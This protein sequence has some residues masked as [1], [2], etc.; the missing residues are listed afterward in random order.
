MKIT[1]S[2]LQKHVAQLPRSDRI[3]DVLVR[4]FSV[5]LSPEKAVS[6][7][8]LIDPVCAKHHLDG[9]VATIIRSWF[10]GHETR[11]RIN[12]VHRPIVDYLIIESIGNR[13][14]QDSVWALGHSEPDPHDDAPG[15]LELIQSLWNAEQISQFCRHVLAALEQV[16][17]KDI[18]IDS[19]YHGS[20]LGR[21]IRQSFDD[22]SLLHQFMRLETHGQDIM[23]YGV[24]LAIQ[25]LVGL[26]LRLKP[27][28]LSKLVERCEH[29]AVRLHAALCVSQRSRKK[30]H[31]KTL[32]WIEPSKCPEVIALGILQTLSTI[33]DLA[34][35]AK[36][37]QRNNTS[38]DSTTRWSTELRPPNDDMKEAASNLL[39]RMVNQLQTFPDKEYGRWIGELLSEAEYFLRKDPETGEQPLVIEL[40]E[41]CVESL[42]LRLSTS[43]EPENITAQLLNGLRL[44]PRDTTIRHLS[45]VAE[46]LTEESKT[47]VNQLYKIVLED[48]HKKISEPFEKCLYI[49]WDR[50]GRAWTEAVYKAL[51][52]QVRQGHVQP[53][54][55]FEQYKAQFP[56]SI[57]DHEENHL[58]FIEAGKR[59][60]YMAALSAGIAQGI[61]QE[62]PES[63]IALAEKVSKVFWKFRKVMSRVE[64]FL[65]ET[66]SEALFHVSL[67]D[68]TIRW[69]DTAPLLEVLLSHNQLPD[70]VLVRL[71][72]SLRNN[73]PESRILTNL[74]VNFKYNSDNMTDKEKSTWA[75]WWKLLGE[76]ELGL[77]VYN[78]LDLSPNINKNWRFL[79]M[80][81]IGLLLQLVLQTREGQPLSPLQEKNSIDEA[82]KLYSNLWRYGEGRGEDLVKNEIDDMLN[83]L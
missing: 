51:Y 17:K 44:P 68:F 16:C 56:I 19:D 13:I 72:L 29:P 2:E 37:A 42:S 67:M 58:D 80:T 66:M 20:G 21:V 61:H 79:T 30:D 1:I 49:N 81:K 26:A 11:R 74:K 31:K 62:D 34:Y 8:E 4:I 43:T 15:P 50:H 60:N 47:L 63:G 65:D 82:R 69:P 28:L 54:E 25:N 77:A 46:L 83:K 40:E 6:P 59:F 5:G 52:W 45:S 27:E 41:I 71:M 64:I 3:A 70:Q 73:T 24:H 76:P 33:A 39:N 53:D 23:Y 55:W 10:T 7:N 22:R 18:V 9:E 57:W 78:N 32:E 12:K 38:W 35:D 75:H 14:D 36:Q 48:F